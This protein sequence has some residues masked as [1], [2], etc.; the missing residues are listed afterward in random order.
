MVSFHW[1][2]ISQVLVLMGEWVVMHQGCHL[3][4]SRPKTIAKQPQ[5]WLTDEQ[6]GNR[7]TIIYRNKTRIRQNCS[8][9][10]AV[11]LSVRFQF[12]GSCKKQVE[13]VKF[14][15]QMQLLFQLQTNTLQSMDY[16]FTIHNNR[17]DE[18]TLA[19][20]TVTALHL[21]DV[22]TKLAGTFCIVCKMFF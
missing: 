5:V 21:Y 20:F 18:T 16:H 4:T 2:F 11:A 15:E 19:W 17:P 13:E 6:W 1:L 14:K 3:D 9:L 10:S 7:Q 12:R 22:Q 8:Y